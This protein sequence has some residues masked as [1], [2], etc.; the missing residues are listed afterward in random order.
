ML[1]WKAGAGSL[2]VWPLFLSFE[3][4]DRAAWTPEVWAVLLTGLT[5]TIIAIWGV[6]SQRL[7]AS[8]KATI[9]LIARNEADADLIEAH[10]DFVKISLAS[11]GTAKWAD[12]AHDGKPQR[13]TIKTVCN[14]FE[15][16]SIGI[17]R[18]VI[19]GKT[20]RLWHKTGT[21]QAWDHAKPFVF[22]LRSRLNNQMIYHEFE[23]LAKLLV[24]NKNPKR[25]WWLGKV[26]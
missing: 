16:I 19:D 23:E 3:Y 6:F 20:W 10:K 11:G 25:N 18:G 8:R 15:L 1:S 26:F 4:P 21:I 7:I 17:Q 12:A 14:Q 22:A 24:E 2:K 9:E 5:A 13:Q